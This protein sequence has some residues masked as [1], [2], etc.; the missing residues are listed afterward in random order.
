MS[1]SYFNFSKKDTEYY[2]EQDIH[3]VRLGFTF[4]NKNIIDEISTWFDYSEGQGTSKYSQHGIKLFIGLNLYES[5]L[6]TLSLRHY[7]KDLSYS[8]LDTSE[9][10]KNS[11]IRANLS[12]KF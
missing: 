4:K 3:T 11:I 8:S 12:Y 2:Q 1:N 5:L 6:L 9:K 10:S 7:Y